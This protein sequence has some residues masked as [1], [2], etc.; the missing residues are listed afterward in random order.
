MLYLNRNL[1]LE[2]NCDIKEAAVALIGVPFDST[3]SYRAGSRTAP[4]EIRREFFELE[5]E[6][7]FF[8]L[9]FCDI[10]NVEAVPGNARETLRCVEDSVNWARQENHGVF[11]LGLGGEHTITHALL[12]GLPKDTFVLSLDAHLDLK[13]D[14]LGEKWSHAA[15]MRRISESGFDVGVI[16]ARSFTSD[17][18]DYAR[19]HGIVHCGCGRKDI[20]KLL[21]N[22]KGRRVYLTL[23]FDAIS[24]HI[25]A[26][27]SNPEPGGLSL[28]DVRFIYNRLIQKST[29]AGADIVEVNPLYDTTATTVMA[30]GIMQDIIV[31]VAGKKR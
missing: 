4:L 26:G 17:E 22:L 21:G 24:P 28:E 19:K 10:G 31:K 25:A 9:P 1:I 8:G 2:S 11:I 18:D 5:K 13:D 23:D 20:E 27:V 16:G 14:Y 6:E 29:L 12:A 15:V 30:A 3:S 7:T